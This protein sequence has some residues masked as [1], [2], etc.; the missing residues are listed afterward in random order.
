MLI[1]KRK[2]TFNGNIMKE[3]GL[4]HVFRP[5]RGVKT[6][7]LNDSPGREYEIYASFVFLKK[8]KQ[9][10][11]RQKEKSSEKSLDQRSIK[12]ER[13]TGQKSAED[14][15]WSMH[16]GSTSKNKICYR[17]PQRPSHKTE[18]VRYMK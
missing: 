9:R 14:A 10:K 17:H 15:E 6:K 11:K 5:W 18:E 7:F 4:P 12:R 1:S 3:E 8:A 13:I 2:H 16:E